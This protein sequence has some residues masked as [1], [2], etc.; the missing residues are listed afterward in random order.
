MSAHQKPTKKEPRKGFSRGEKA[1]GLVILFF[2]I[3]AIYSFSQPSG[4]QT[5]TTTGT[6]LTSTAASTSQVPGAPDFTLPVIGPN[7]LTSEKISLS[8]FRGKVVF[9]EFMEPWCEVCQSMA[10][11]VVRLY[12]QF[13]PQNVVFLAVAG[14]WQGATADD[15]AKF[16]R[17]YGTPWTYVYDSSGSIFNTYGV[18]GTPTFFLIAK[19]GSI[20]TRYEGLNATYDILAADLTRLNK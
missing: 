16:M 14:P 5:T 17:D 7:G 19:N 18:Q 11:T 9:L 8:S 4:P 10:P 3:W 15:A 13:G 12:Q 2:A 6:A 20:Q 1:I